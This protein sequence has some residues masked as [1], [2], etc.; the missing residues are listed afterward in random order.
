MADEVVTFRLKSAAQRVNK[1]T[2]GEMHEW[3]RQRAANDRSVIL[4]PSEVVAAARPAVAYVN[5][6]HWVADCP[7]RSCDLCA[8]PCGAAMDL[9][10]DRAAPYLCGCCH[11]AELRGRWRPVRWPAERVHREIESVLE[12]RP[13]DRNRHWW[14][15]ETV[16]QLR[17]E[18]RAHGLPAG[19]DA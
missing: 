10:P 19:G 8:G 4:P 13:L 3:L 5:H 17:A 14:P 6:G 15:H 1:R 12:Q 2:L 9:L 11:N 16:E 18:N 7:A